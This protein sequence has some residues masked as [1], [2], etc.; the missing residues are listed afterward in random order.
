MH[1]LIQK[2]RFSPWRIPL[3]LVA[4]CVL[5]FGL[6]IPWL[7]FYHDEWHFIY[8][9]S[10]RGTQG[11]V[12]LFNYDGHPLGVWSYIL[13]FG[14]LGD[15]P[16]AWHLYSLL[17]RWLAVAVFWLCLKRLWPGHD[18]QTG[19]AA[20]LFALYPLFTLQVLPI[21]YSEVWLSFFLLWLSFYLSLEAI[22][23]PEKFG[24][25][26]ALAVLV[27]IAHM[28][29]S[30]YTWFVEVMRPVFI[31][32]MLPGKLPA[33]ERLRKTLQIWAP[34]FLIFLG[35]VLWRAFFY[36][37]GRKEIAFQSGLVTNPLGL[38]DVVFRYAI[39][40]SAQILFTSWYQLLQPKY[41]DLGNR[42]N[43]FVLA[44][45]LA[46]AAG[47]FFFLSKLG[48]P[49][50]AEAQQD[51]QW[52]RQALIL[53]LSGLVFGLLPAYA[54][55]YSIY[56]SAPPGNARFALG[57]LPGAALI[58][59]ALLE[60]VVSSPRVKMALIAVLAGLL[61]GWHVR[62]TNEFRDLWTYQVS[63][64]RQLTW[65][66][67]GLAPDT[68]LV[69]TEKFFPDI[70]YP[71]AILAVSGDY[72]TAMA[73][74][75]I[76]RARAQA[77]GRLPYW[78]FPKID[79]PEDFGPDASLSAEHLDSY[80]EGNGRHNLFFSFA[81]QN[82]ECLHILRPEDA[83]YRRLPDNI[84]VL[85]AS[86]SLDGIDVSARAD[87]SRLDAILGPEHTDT[88][89][90]FYERADLAG[91]KQ[92]WAAIPALWDSAVQKGLRA[93]NGREYLPFVEASIRLNDWDR[94]LELTG[95]ANKLSPNMADLYCPLW[96]KLANETPPSQQKAALLKA[97][98]SLLKCAA[99]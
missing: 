44:L 66:A 85:A 31:W 57:A 10:M 15:H 14:L 75:T 18:R 81:P 8:Y 7:G 52:P 98:G 64:Y 37:A 36:Q 35:M 41:L 65:R 61:I 30:E 79:A 97:A 46:S 62:Y 93:R 60:M 1:P 55:G 78:F 80:F 87:F 49:A 94:A 21:S 11:L 96:Q 27:N 3:L 24:L 90:Y 33:A 2:L 6:F 47:A 71:S 45:I 13:G 20:L 34:Y 50:D 95:S 56:L 84:K 91:Q 17:W 53:G 25:F 5:A 72:P 48:P 23:R 16:L 82:G 73:I 68:A 32:F 83:A 22:A 38:V 99:P 28:F 12:D 40:D 86:A 92:D 4:A 39:P 42:F 88:W 26:T 43:L 19:T 74:N 54:A 59:T 63:F 67:P 89:C 76:Y 77:N 70:E 58:L 29:T 51:G 69:A 9:Q